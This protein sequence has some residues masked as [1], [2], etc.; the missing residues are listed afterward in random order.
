MAETS[1]RTTTK[2]P[3]AFFDRSGELLKRLSGV[4]VRWTD[5][6]NRAESAL[7][8][9]SNAATRSLEVAIRGTSG[10][11]LSGEG[12]GVAIYTAVGLVVVG[13][14]GIAIGTR[15]EGWEKEKVGRERDAGKN[16]SEG[17]A[18]QPIGTSQE[19]VASN[20]G[21]V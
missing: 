7:G 21:E 19:A 14:A 11:Y 16:E 5:I 15:A 1:A 8:E 3:G 20:E 6:Y 10:D 2:A 18:L 12:G 13:T 9:L 17:K 4:S